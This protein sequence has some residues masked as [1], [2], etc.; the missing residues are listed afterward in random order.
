M[1][2]GKKFVA[3]AAG[4][5]AAAVVFGSGFAHA[6]DDPGLASAQRNPSIA[7][8][9]PAGQA[10]QG[11]TFTGTQNITCTQTVSSVTTTP[12]AAGP[13]Y[14]LVRQQNIC[15]AMS[16]GTCSTILECPEGKQG[17]GSGITYTNFGTPPP[18]VLSNGPFPPGTDNGRRWGFSI[19]NPSPDVDVTWWATLICIRDN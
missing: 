2:L 13:G 18:L 12:A 14:Q 19:R 16:T 1:K 7:F 8:P 17:S 9:C 11:N 10:G 6:Q 15:G 4:V 5:A 3:R